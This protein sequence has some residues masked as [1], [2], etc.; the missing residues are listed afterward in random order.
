MKKFLIK[1]AIFAVVLYGLAWGLDYAISKGLYQMD[2]YRFISWREMQ[3]GNINADIL[4]VGN[5]RALSHFEPWTID[6]I[7]GTTSYNLG[8]GGYAI[9]VSV[10]KYQYYRLYNEKPKIII[11]QADLGTILNDSAPH[12]HQSEQ[13]LPLI[14]DRRMHKELRRVGYT[15]L[16]IYCP[17]YRYWGYQVVIKQGLLEC[18]GIKHYICDSSRQGFHYER[19]EWNGSELAKLDTIY[20]RINP[21]GRL[22]FESYMRQCYEEG[23]KVILV[24]TPTY[25]GATNK[26]VG[27]EQIDAYFDSIAS[28]YNTVYWNYT[29][30]EICND[31]TNFVVSVHMNPRA[32]HKFCVKI[33]NRLKDECFGVFN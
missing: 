26:M 9:M 6:S 3:R 28:E 4:Y 25:I 11:Q 30:D 14:Y 2:D 19:G 32:T 10:L 27:L 24:N 7:C 5:S 23:I 20:A 31:T 12:R 13:F 29:Y 8:I 16:D 18:M 15:I 21:A 22:R 1:I 17:L 33:A